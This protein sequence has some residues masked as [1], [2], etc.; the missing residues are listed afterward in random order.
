MDKHI[1]LAGAFN[2]AMGIMGILGVIA[3]SLMMATLESYIEE[4]DA[5]AIVVMAVSLGLSYLA[6]FSIAQIICATGLLKRKSWSRVLLIIVSAFK[7]PSAPIGTALGIYTIWV[8]IQDETRTI[9][10]TGSRVQ[11]AQLRE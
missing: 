3:G 11:S 10:E 4:P 7:L 2:L 1:T 8:L 9:L 6:V 5:A